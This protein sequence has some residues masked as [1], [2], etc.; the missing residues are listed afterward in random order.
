MKAALVGMTGINRLKVLHGYPPRELD[1][2]KEDAL[3]GSYFKTLRESLIVSENQSSNVK[4]RR[5]LSSG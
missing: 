2:S 1:L 5:V 3:L 4:G